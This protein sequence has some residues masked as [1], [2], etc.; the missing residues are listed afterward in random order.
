MTPEVLATTSLGLLGLSAVLRAAKRPS[1]R[2]AATA[3][4]PLELELTAGVEEGILSRSEST[5]AASVLRL[6]SFRARD[7][8][9]PASR[10]PSLALP[11]RGDTWTRALLESVESRALVRDP[12]GRVVGIVHAVDLA[13]AVEDGRSDLSSVIRPLPQ[14]QPDLPLSAL[15]E[16][17]SGTGVPLAA[18]ETPPGV[19]LAV[20]RTRDVVEELV[21]SEPGR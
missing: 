12:D 16:K 10:L 2:R 6:A 14:V 13:F 7:V 19:P 3:G 9:V 15:L 11:P 21:G 8:A 4:R 1:S 17:L 18:L 20:V 5:L